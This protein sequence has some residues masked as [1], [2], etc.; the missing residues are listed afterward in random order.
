VRGIE[1][2]VGDIFECPEGHKARIVW[3]SEERK[4]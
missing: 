2:K 3:I 4:V 1:L